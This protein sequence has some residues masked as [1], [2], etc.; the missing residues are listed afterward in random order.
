MVDEIDDDIYKF[1]YAEIVKEFLIAM[2]DLINKYDIQSKNKEISGEEVLKWILE[3]TLR[4]AEIA[5]RVGKH[6]YF[7]EIRQKIIE[8]LNIFDKPNL[9][10]V[11]NLIR[12]A[13][14]KATSIGALSHKELSKK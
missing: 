8:S 6:K 4:E 1:T 11:L 5:I 12:D 9:E 10:H 13:L 7:D 14:T 3:I 2:L